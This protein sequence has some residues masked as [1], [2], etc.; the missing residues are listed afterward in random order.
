MA[1]KLYVQILTLKTHQVYSKR[2]VVYSTKDKSFRRSPLPLTIILQDR[3]K[4][5]VAATNTVVA[6]QNARTD[7]NFEN[8]KRNLVVPM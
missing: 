6:M 2:S 5:V 7:V 1:T 8:S 4:V 3:M